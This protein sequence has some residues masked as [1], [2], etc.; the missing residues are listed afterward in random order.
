MDSSRGF[1]GQYAPRGDHGFRPPQDN[2]RAR[3]CNGP[4]SSNR[5]VVWAVWGETPC[6]PTVQIAE[7]SAIRLK[8]SPEGTAELAGLTLEHGHNQWPSARATG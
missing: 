8:F 1:G 5:R 7:R 3:P 4:P 6:L 2:W